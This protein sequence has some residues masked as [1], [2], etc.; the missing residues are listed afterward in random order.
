MG[1]GRGEKQHYPRAA[2]CALTRLC[3]TCTMT[4]ALYV[5]P[6]LL[7]YLAAAALLARRMM[8]EAS[9]PTHAHVPLALGLVAAIL[10]ALYHLAI[11]QRIGGPD[12]HFF[13]AL[14]LVGMA[15]AAV[16][17]ALAWF[18]PVATIGVAAFPLAAA[19][20]A[21]DALIGHPRATGATWQITLHAGFAL[22]A[23]ATLSIAAVVAVAL[24]LQD[25]ALKRRQLGTLV[26]ILPPLT[27]V[28]ALLF[29]LIA[30]GF[31]LLTLTLVT[32]VLF[33][34]NLLAQHLVHKTVLSVAAWLVFAWLLFGRWRWGWRG[35]RAAQW[36]LGG[37]ALLLLAFIGSKFVLEILL[38]RT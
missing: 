1:S 6:A 18:R 38:Q 10:H 14:S 33:I 7:L 19:V 8:R 21:V 11:S 37:M 12:L 35:R 26:R 31:L 36:T 25:R 22:V 27:L 3:D 28:E 34:E 24:Y 30:A 20:L 2:S 4:H 16:T 32:G 17:V 13:A 29:Q 9:Q 15:M 5:V 23:Y